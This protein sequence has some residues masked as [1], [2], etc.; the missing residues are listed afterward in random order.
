MGLNDERRGNSWQRYFGFLKCETIMVHI[1]LFAFGKWRD[2]GRNKAIV[3]NLGGPCR[4]ADN[5]GR[6]MDG[7]NMSLTS[8][9]AL[10]EPSALRP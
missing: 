7:I 9:G 8:S 5:G 2:Y 10:K 3:G 4:S 1:K 6:G